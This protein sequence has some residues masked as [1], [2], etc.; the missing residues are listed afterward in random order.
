MNLLNVVKNKYLQNYLNAHKVLRNKKIVSLDQAKTIGVIAEVTDEDS[1]KHIYSIF[2]KLQSYPKTVWLM[3]Y[4]NQKLVPYYCLQQ[5]TADYFCNKH[6]NW[7]GKP[8][9]VQMK[10]FLSKDFDMLIDLNSRS[11]HPNHFILQQSHARFI[12]GTVKESQHL[13]DLFID[14]EQM[15]DKIELL[16][17]IHYYTKK[18]T[19]E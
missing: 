19:G 12:V 11:Y 6:I 15:D 10:D 7:F 4:I 1:Y 16:K 3:C 5:L 14:S 9:F 17:H 18:L 13:Y 2:T 8:D